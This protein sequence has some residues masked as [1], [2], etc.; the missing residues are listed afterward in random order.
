MYVQLN[1]ESM[2]NTVY[3]ISYIGWTFELLECTVNDKEV[4][5]FNK[6]IKIC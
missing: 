3:I 1:N 2:T 6:A 5:N 4:D